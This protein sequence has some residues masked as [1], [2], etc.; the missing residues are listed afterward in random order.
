MKASTATSVFINYSIEDAVQHIAA[1]G[2]DGVDIW[3]GRPHVYRRDFTSDELDRLRRLIENLGLSVP[4]FMPAFFRYPY[5]LINPRD[6]VREDSIQYMRECADN[7]VALGA[8]MMLIVIGHTLHGQ[9]RADAW[10]RLLDSIHRVCEYASQ[11][12]LKLA[13]EPANRFVTDLVNTAQDA[14]RLVAEV[15]CPNLGVALDT[16]HIHLSEESGEE[17]I[18]RLGGYLFEVHVNDNDGNTQQNLVPGEGSFDFQRFVHKLR[19][20]GYDG[21]LTAELGWQYTLDP[22][23]AARLALQRIRAMAQ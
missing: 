3:G 6:P 2:Y 12:G 8:G 11:Y 15:G 13:V 20:S 5:S 7:A 14:M 22:I 21:F 16:G 17:A 18:D 1:L 10:Q 23:P 19:A 9:T 4:C